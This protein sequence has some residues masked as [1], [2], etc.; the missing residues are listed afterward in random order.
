MRCSEC[1]TL[2]SDTDLFCGECGA[3][4]SPSLPDEPAGAPVVGGALEPASPL[5]LDLPVEPSLPPSTPKVRDTRAN[6]AFILGVVSAASIVAIC[7]PVFGS[8]I[9]C[10]GPVAGILAI[11][12]GAIVKRDIRTRGGLQED[13]KRAHQGMILGIASIVIQVGLL[14]LGLLLGIGAGLLGEF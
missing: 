10:L 11:I 4:L 5:P 14:A 7:I 1:G 8:L 9:G 3:I 2:A 6:A 13:W 12:L